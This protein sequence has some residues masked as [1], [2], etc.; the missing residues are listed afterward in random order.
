MGEYMKFYALLATS[1]V[2][3]LSLSSCVSTAPAQVGMSITDYRKSCPE[4][5]SSINFNGAEAI[6]EC[7]SKPYEYALFRNGQIASILNSDEVSAHIAADICPL[8][9]QEPNCAS[10]I[11]QNIAVRE[12]EKVRA[13]EASSNKAVGSAFAAFARGLAPDET[14]A[15][16]ARYAGQPAPTPTPRPTNSLLP[17]YPL[18]P[19]A[20]TSTQQ[21][22]PVISQPNPAP[23]CHSV[24]Q[25]SSG[26]YRACR[27]LC[28][29]APFEKT[30]PIGT[31]CPP[32]ITL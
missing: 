8:L 1:I 29:G 25:S 30:Y 3:G 19:P 32:S 24:G 28:S 21:S 4:G 23:V 18:F 31:S 27:Y 20:P 7:N 6:G 16:D 22:S 9:S 5:Q 14:A 11:R 26:M 17:Q 15:I 13:G 10:R 12:D 2:A